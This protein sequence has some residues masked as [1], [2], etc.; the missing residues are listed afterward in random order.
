MSQPLDMHISAMVLFLHLFDMCS[1][2]SE[3][4]T[5]C[6]IAWN[7]HCGKMKCTINFVL[8]TFEGGSC[9]DSLIC[10]RGCGYSLM[11]S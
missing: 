9:T 5:Q 3:S 8:A 2:L 10:T 6:Y 7:F 11:Y 4:V 1:F